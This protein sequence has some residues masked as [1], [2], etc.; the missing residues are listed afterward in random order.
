MK[1]AKFVRELRKYGLVDKSWIANKEDQKI[2]NHTVTLALKQLKPNL[3]DCEFSCGRQVENQVIEYRR[4]PRIPDMWLR[5]CASCGLYQHPETGEMVDHRLINKWF[6]P[7]NK[8]DR[9]LEE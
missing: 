1:Y 8:Q 5:K 9:D 7:R 6:P 3:R 4:L 2:L